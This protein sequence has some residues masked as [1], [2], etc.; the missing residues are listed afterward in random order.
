MKNLKIKIT[1]SFVLIAICAVSVI[2][3]NNFNNPEQA[4]IKDF[5]ND[6]FDIVMNSLGN[7]K[8]NIQDSNKTSNKSAECAKNKPAIYANGQPTV[9]GILKKN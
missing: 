2:I 4:K 8:D 7:N 5:F 6:K 9:I 1:S 3:Y